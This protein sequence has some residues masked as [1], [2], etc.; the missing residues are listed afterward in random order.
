MCNKECTSIRTTGDRGDISTG[1]THIRTQPSVCG[2]LR[3]TNIIINNADG[4]VVVECLCAWK[5]HAVTRRDRKSRNTK[6][7]AII[8]PFYKFF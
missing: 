3:F 7:Y 2:V 4:G 5:V 6:G 1:S 8:P